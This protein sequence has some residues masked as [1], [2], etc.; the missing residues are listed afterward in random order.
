MLSS[1][2]AASLRLWTWREVESARASSQWKNTGVHIPC[3]SGAFR[4]FILPTGRPCIRVAPVQR[5]RVER[6]PSASTC[7]RLLY[8]RLRGG[9]CERDGH[10]NRIC[11]LASY[12]PTEAASAS[13]HRDTFRPSF[14]IG[15]RIRVANATCTVDA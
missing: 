11:K 4:V 9:R 2:G 15:D 12:D 14:R 7:S 3:Y 8:L 1:N 10:R 13:P 5:G 6:P